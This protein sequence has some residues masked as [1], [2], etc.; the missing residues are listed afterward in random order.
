SL[1]N[2]GATASA[3]DDGQYIAYTANLNLGATAADVVID[4][5]DHSTPRTLL[6]QTGASVSRPRVRFVGARLVTGT[7]P[8]GQTV[9][10]ISSWDPAGGP[11]TT[12][13]S[14]ARSGFLANGPKTHVIA[15]DPMN[16]A[17]L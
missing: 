8:M 11:A 6:A 16:N 17:L 1:Y 3:S 2:Y 14:P 7:T 4:R 13:L 5:P 9:H 15:A 10:T 12:L